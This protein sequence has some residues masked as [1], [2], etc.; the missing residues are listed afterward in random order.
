M[1]GR[2]IIEEAEAVGV[3][4]SAEFMFINLAPE[5]PYLNNPAIANEGKLVLDVEYGIVNS[6]RGGRLHLHSKEELVKFFSAYGMDYGYHI[7]QKDLRGLKNNMLVLQEQYVDRVKRQALGE[8][9]HP[10]KSSFV[11]KY[12]V[13]DE[14]VY[15]SVKHGY[16]KYQNL[17]VMN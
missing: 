8:M 12:D 10:A 1:K 16:K 5:E 17:S 9:V 2:K 15:D 7:D 13:E 3:I 14:S 11:K 6:R 4:K